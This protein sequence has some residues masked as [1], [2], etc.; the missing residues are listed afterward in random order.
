MPA[1]SLISG[2]NARSDQ[3]IGEIP[4]EGEWREGCGPVGN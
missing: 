2:I 3:G 1:T 4:D